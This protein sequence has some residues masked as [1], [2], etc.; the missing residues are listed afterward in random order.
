MVA[1]E[2][3]MK[4][5]NL[6]VAFVAVLL[7]TGSAWA[8][9]AKKSSSMGKVETAQGTIVS[10]SSSEL[11]ITA[12]VKGKEEQETFVINPETKT[13]GD[14]TAGFMAKVH[15]RSENGQNVAT[16]ISSHKMMA[17]KKK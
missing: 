11:V 14:L 10:S 2:K 12:K 13:A 9:A 3:F 1:R 15:Y 5:N 7:L 4:R 16:Q 8:A 6:L 17:S